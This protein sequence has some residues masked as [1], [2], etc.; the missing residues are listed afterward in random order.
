MAESSP[1]WL[2]AALETPGWMDEPELVW[3]RARA[4]TSRSVVEVGCWLGRSTIALAGCLGPVWTV[5]HFGGSP[6]EHETSHAE[7]LEPGRDLH[8]EAT[9]SLAAYPNVTILKMPSLNA[10]RLFAPGSVDMV[11]IDGEHTRLAVLVDLLAWHPKARRLL[12]G[13]DVGM[14]GVQ[15]ALA[16]YGLPFQLGPGSIWYAELGG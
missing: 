8:A 3:L 16:T 7:A 9:A 5:D 1:A 14:D 4:R 15:E 10:S 12:C 2:S 13:H 11:F 6:S